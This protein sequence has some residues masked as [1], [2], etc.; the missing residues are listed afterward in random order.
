VFVYPVNGCG[1]DGHIHRF[2][3]ATEYAS[4]HFHRVAGWTGP[5]IPQPDGTHVHRIDA[6]LDAEPFRFRGGAY[7]TVA[8]LP[9]HAHRVT[10][11]TGP[12]L[13]GEPADW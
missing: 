2:Q 1:T 12:P 4:G 3:G 13:G 5:A 9:R 11:M 6:L 7:E 10:A 8:V